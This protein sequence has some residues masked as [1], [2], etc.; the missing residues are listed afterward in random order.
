MDSLVS[1]DLFL[2]AQPVLLGLGMLLAEF[3]APALS[4]SKII[5]NRNKVIVDNV[6]TGL[7][8]FMMLLMGVLVFAVKVSNI[9]TLFLILAE[10][11][12]FHQLII[13]M[14]RREEKYDFF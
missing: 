2:A 5:V 7:L 6:L 13:L 14:C 10:A 12:I 8:A 1:K 4:P 9:E 11:L 3:W